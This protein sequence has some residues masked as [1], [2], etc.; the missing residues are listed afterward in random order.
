MQV[1]TT[2]VWGE[3]DHA[4]LPGLIEGLGRWVPRLRLVRVAGASHWIV[5]EQPAL[6]AAE[7]ARAIV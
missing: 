5:H 1:P 7:I 4:L 2:V 6:V 3:Q